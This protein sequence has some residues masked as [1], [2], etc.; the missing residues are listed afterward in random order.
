MSIRLP[1]DHAT[2]SAS[3]EFTLIQTD[4]QSQNRAGTGD[5]DLILPV[6]LLRVEAR[7]EVQRLTLI[8]PDGT[9]ET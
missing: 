5:D 2:I 9:R 4:E 6:G 8:Q 7:R 1:F 3:L